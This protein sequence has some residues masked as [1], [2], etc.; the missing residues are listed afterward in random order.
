MVVTK[1]RWLVLSSLMLLLHACGTY[2]QKH[3]K[4]HQLFSANRLEEADALLA[5]D[6]RAERRK[7]K[8]LYYFN[9]GVVTHLMG[10]YKESN[11]FFEQAHRTHESFST[12]YMEETLAFVINP[13]VADYQGEDHEVLLL[14]YYK[15]LNFLQLG[16]YDAALVECRRLNIKLN[17]LQDKYRDDAQ[18]YRRDA[19]IHTLMGLVYQANHDYNNAFIAYRNAVEIYQE[20]Y[21]RLFGFSAPLQLKKDLIYT[22]YKTGFHDEVARYQRLFQLAY[23]PAQ[24]HDACDVIVLWNNGL[25]PI[26]NEWG[27]DFI[28]VKGAGGTLLFRNKALGLVFPFPLP[29]DRNQQGALLN[30]RFIRVAFPEYVERPLL[31]NQAVVATD[32]GKQQ[33]LELLENINA[34]SFQVLRQRMVWELSKS[35]LRVALK[36]ALAYQ[37]R[38]QNNVLGLIVGGINFATEKADTRNWQTLPHSIHY[39]RLRLPAGTHQ[40]R[41]KAFAANALRNSYQEE[42]CLQL[43]PGKTAFR[44][45]HSPFTASSLGEQAY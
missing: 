44:L 35:L 25:G 24:D 21:Q 3:R 19:F 41:F 33:S 11:Q 20:D 1:F 27:I 22:A 43:S 32:R 15:A 2:Y 26:K 30:L 40:I 37:V 38:K 23:D 12:N 13:T 10:R 8:L 14:H 16:Q 5:Q 31:Y 36:Q 4:F 34:I 29:A 45:V 42:F 39:A 28:L 17:Q 7:T 9:R 6:K 18:K